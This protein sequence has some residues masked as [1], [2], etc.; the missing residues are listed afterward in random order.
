MVREQTPTSPWSS[1]TFTPTAGPDRYNPQTRTWDDPLPLPPEV[2]RSVRN[3]NHGFYDPEL[4]AYF[5]HFASDSSDNGTMWAYR[6]K[7]P[8]S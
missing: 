4:N 6:Y 1:A 7:K 3:G 2:V 5:C 8:K